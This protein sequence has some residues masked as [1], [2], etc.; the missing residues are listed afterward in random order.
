MHGAIVSN[1]K[2]YLDESLG[3]DVW[4]D[5][6]ASTGL[7]GKTYMPVSL[8]PDSEMEALLQAAEAA[9]GLCRD[10]LLHD[11][12]EW[13]MT[14]MLTMYQAM[15]PPGSD[16]L[17]FIL[18]LPA[19]HERI[20]KLKDPEASAPAIMVR[21]RSVDTL[22]I[23]YRSSRNMGAMIPGAVKGVADWFE[24]EVV[25]AERVQKE[26]GETVF[27]FLRLA[28]SPPTLQAV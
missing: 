11:F 27:V 16:T 6:V 5:M 3:Q 2:R 19:M 23:G 8:Y 28:N 14:P 25:M 24:E 13:L 20:L 15:I 12:G 22:E 10:S 4:Q 21:R 1:F 17:S 26:T 7:A 18:Q 9:T